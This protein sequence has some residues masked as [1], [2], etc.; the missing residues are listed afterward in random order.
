MECFEPVPG[1]QR[2]QEYAPSKVD[3]NDE[4]IRGD[5]PPPDSV[6]VIPTGRA[7]HTLDM[8]AIGADRYMPN[9]KHKYSNTMY[10]LVQRGMKC[11]KALT[12]PNQRQCPTL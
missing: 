10:R 4:V 5:V 9:S 1:L 6:R 8:I 12:T 11:S 3:K 7:E 2:R